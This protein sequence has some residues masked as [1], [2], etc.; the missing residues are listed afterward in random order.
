MIVLLVHYGR[1]RSPAA[2]EGS[3][4]TAK[5]LTFCL[6]SLYREY[7]AAF[8]RRVVLVHPVA[9]L[10]GIARYG[11]GGIGEPERWEGG[12]GS[13]VGVGFCLKPM[14]PGCPSGRAN[15]R[16]LFFET[17][18]EA[19]PA[20]CRDCSIRIIGQQALRCGSALYIMTSARDILED[21]LLPAL[22]QRR[23]QR[24]LLTMCRYSFEPIGLA[25]AICGIEARLVP[26]AHGDCR[27]YSTWRRADTGDKPEQTSMEA[28]SFQRLIS[29][30]SG[31]EPGKGAPRFRKTGNV[32]Q[33]C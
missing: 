2:A 29:S 31:L 19:D 7:G 3:T 33:P 23:F 10:R 4:V 28:T 11:R 26:F 9:T 13:L 16:C 30:F 18:A 25:L 17:G 22:E 6:R 32:Y 5:L 21:V 27:D 14:A 24:A 1:R 20:S 15:H 8:L 12:E